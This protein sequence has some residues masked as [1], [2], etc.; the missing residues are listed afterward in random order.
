MG[1]TF[2]DAVHVLG[3]DLTDDDVPPDTYD[4]TD[5]GGPDNGQQFTLTIEWDGDPMLARWYAST[6]ATL[7]RNHVEGCVVTFTDTTL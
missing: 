2:D 1:S 3:L 7:A 5:P 6:L 4:Y